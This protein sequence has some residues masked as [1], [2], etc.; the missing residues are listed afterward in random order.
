MGRSSNVLM[1]VERNSLSTLYCMS[2]SQTVPH[3]VRWKPT[4]CWT[5]RSYVLLLRKYHNKCV[6]E[7]GIDKE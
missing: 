2:Y 1:S 4:A 3:G 6:H 5:A 7:L